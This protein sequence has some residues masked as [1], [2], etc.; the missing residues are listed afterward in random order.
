MILNNTSVIRKFVKFIRLT[1]LKTRNHNKKELLLILF[2]IQNNAY[3]YLQK[4]TYFQDICQA[5]IVLLVY[6]KVAWFFWFS[7]FRIQYSMML[8]IQ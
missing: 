6:F 5:F 7:D 8:N 3:F 1:K 4:V 2:N